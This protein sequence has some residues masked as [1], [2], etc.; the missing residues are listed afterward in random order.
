M[1]TF[2]G[3]CYFDCFLVFV[4]FGFEFYYGVAYGVLF[5]IGV[6]EGCGEM[7][8]GWLRIYRLFFR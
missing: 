7:I 2:I 1:D 8:V 6:V 5:G 3:G 4:V